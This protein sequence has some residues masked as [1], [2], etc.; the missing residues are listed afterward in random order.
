[1][2]WG[3]ICLIHSLLSSVIHYKDLK[4]S[5]HTSY[6]VWDCTY[7]LSFPNIHKEVQDLQKITAIAVRWYSSDREFIFSHLTERR[8]HKKFPSAGKAWVCWLMRI[9]VVPEARVK[10]YITFFSPI[11][12]DLP[13]RP[14]VYFRER[15]FSLMVIAQGCKNWFGWG[16]NLI[17]Y[18]GSWPDHSTY[19]DTKYVCSIKIL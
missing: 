4:F 10:I 18:T 13:F 11:L 14:M 9:C 3:V 7:V 17:Y 5:M 6:R 2:G 19:T 16:G 1:M 15:A 8:G 12:S